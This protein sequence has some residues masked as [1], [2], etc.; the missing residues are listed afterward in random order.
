MKITKSYLKQLIREELNNLTEQSSDDSK[1][2]EP[3]KLTADEKKQTDAYASEKTFLVK[4]DDGN[5]YIKFPV[6]FN[7][8]EY[9]TLVTL[10]ILNP[11]RNPTI[12]DRMNPQKPLPE[13][14]VNAAF[15]EG[16]GFRA[17]F[18][19]TTFL[20]MIALRSYRMDHFKDFKDEVGWSPFE[21]KQ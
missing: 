6:N 15:R 1:G 8:G 14:F 12:I 4:R 18:F 20:K 21:V 17:K 13:N 9:K 10:N 7:K 16:S 19:N 11:E 5:F 3:R 2:K